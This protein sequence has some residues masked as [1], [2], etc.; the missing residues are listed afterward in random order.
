MNLRSKKEMAARTF[1]VGKEKIL[2]VKSRIEDI[3]EAIT[4]QDLRDLKTD[5]AIVIKEKKG[6]KKVV[7][8]RNRSIGNVRKKP[9]VRKRNYVI[10]TRK[11]RSYV[12]EMKKQG[13]L[14]DEEVK[15]IRKKIRNKQYRSKAHLKE[16]IGG[17]QK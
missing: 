5:G 11:L 10:M 7:K 14:S 9:N 6:R 4:K 15:E 3:K 2:F 13:K 1:K 12:A 8:K 17:K 16:Q